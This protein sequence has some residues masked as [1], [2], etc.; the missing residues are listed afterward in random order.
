MRAV[1]KMYGG[2]RTS[3]SSLFL[4]PFSSLALKRKGRRRGREPSCSSS[5]SLS[6]LEHGRKSLSNTRQPPTSLH[7][8]VLLCQ[9]KDKS[10]FLLL[11]L[12]LFGSS[13]EFLPVVSRQRATAAGEVC[14]HSPLRELP[15][16]CF[17]FA[18][19]C[20]C[21]LLSPRY[22]TKRRSAVRKEEEAEQENFLSVD[23]SAYSCPTSERQ[24]F[25][26]RGGRRRA[27]KEAV[28]AGPRAEPERNNTKVSFRKLFLFKLAMLSSFLRTWA[29]CACRN[30]KETKERAEG[31]EACEGRTDASWGRKTL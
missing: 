11:F 9:I 29:A 27:Q 15:L 7:L 26:R 17:L 28:K 31:K 25:G 3:S 13:R 24:E 6:T 22:F 20:L 10:F 1:E 23:V 21:F 2:S 4:C 18:S 12:P 5:P 14:R 30:R 19:F 16:F 8:R